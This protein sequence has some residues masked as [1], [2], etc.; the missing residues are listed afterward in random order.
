MKYNIVERIF[1]VKKF[2]ELKHTTSIQRVRRT[3]FP[4]S[5]GP[6]RSVIQNIISNFKKIGLVDHVP[7][8]QKN[9]SQKREA[10]KI[11]LRIIFIVDP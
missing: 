1:L 5:T 7:P 11:Q 8:K 4:K 2:Y 3:Q 10:A 9:P 6:S